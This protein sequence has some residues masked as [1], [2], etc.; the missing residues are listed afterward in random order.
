MD[1]H[2]DRIQSGRKNQHVNKREQEKMPFSF[3]EKNVRYT[4][5]WSFR[6]SD[7]NCTN[8]I[9]PEAARKIQ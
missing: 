1:G 2:L 3:Q 4:W 8:N 5:I 6:Y 7:L 9:F